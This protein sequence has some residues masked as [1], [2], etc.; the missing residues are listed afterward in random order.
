[1]GKPVKACMESTCA[2]CGGRITPGTLILPHP[3]KSVRR[4]LHAAKCW[5]KMNKKF[6]AGKKATVA[7]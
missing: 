7:A 6:Q 4:W 5:A 2:E 1:M 3:L